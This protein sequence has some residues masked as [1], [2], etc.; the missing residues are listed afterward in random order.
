MREEGQLLIRDV[1]AEIKQQLMIDAEA[2]DSNVQAMAVG[3]LA[4]EFRQPYTPGRSRANGA[5]EDKLTLNLRMPE[6]L[7]K[8]IRVRAA[9]QGLAHADLALLILG[10][11]LGIEIQKSRLNRRSRK[12]VAA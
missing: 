4:D 11:H 3:I 9:Q 6:K 5:H 2:A 7:H 1:P 8:A 12:R 10:K